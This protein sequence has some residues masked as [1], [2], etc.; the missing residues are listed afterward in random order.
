LACQ[1]I[2]VSP[3]IQG[4]WIA[5]IGT[6]EAGPYASQD[7]ALRVAVAEAGQI[8]SVDRHICIVVQDASGDVSAARCTCYAFEQMLPER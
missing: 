2:V 1:N 7:L 8:R 5:K 4:G 3:T 6:R